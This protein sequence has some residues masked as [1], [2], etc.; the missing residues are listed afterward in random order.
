MTLSLTLQDIYVNR[1]VE[2]VDKLQ[3]TIAMYDAQITAQREETKAAEDTLA[4][5]RLEIEV[6]AWRLAYRE[7]SVLGGSLG[8]R[9]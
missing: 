7:R 6:S 1:L 8:D 5:A 9:V 2:R 4:E 3:E